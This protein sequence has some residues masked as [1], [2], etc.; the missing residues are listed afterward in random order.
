MARF[1]GVIGFVTTND[2]NNGVHEEVATEYNY[3]GD[4]I[5]N[6]RRLENG[7]SLNDNVVINNQFSI[8]ADAYAIQNFQNMR[9]VK[10]MGVSWKITN[11]E[12][13]RPRLILTAGGVYNG[14]WPV[15]S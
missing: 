11:V 15:V 7:I 8:I 9:Y 4:V 5:R 10:W 12:V 3:R 1:Y 14:P 13:Q 2:N 6:S